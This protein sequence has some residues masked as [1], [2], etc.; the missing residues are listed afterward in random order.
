ML[1]IT[2]P[3]R[4]LSSKDNE[5]ATK[6]RAEYLAY[7]SQE[8][9]YYTSLHKQIFVREIPH[10]MLLHVNRLNA[11]V[12]EHLL[13]LFEQKQYLFKTLDAALSDPAYDMPDRF[14][15]DIQRA[16]RCGAIGGLKFW[17]C[18]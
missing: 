12:I 18:G 5:S 3:L 16:D 9:D 8:I 10:I 6:V 1:S 4:A 11:D 7:T 17:M 14:L 13:E 2:P 15:R